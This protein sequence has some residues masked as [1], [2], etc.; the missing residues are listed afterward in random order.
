LP[1]T[2]GT[3]GHLTDREWLVGAMVPVRTANQD[4]EAILQGVLVWVAVSALL[5]MVWALLRAVADSPGRPAPEEHQRRCRSLAAGP[6]RGRPGSAALTPR[7]R[8]CVA[9]VAVAAPW[10]PVPVPPP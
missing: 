8:S 10:V 7:L 9:R 4:G 2:P 6:R 3:G 1:E 5:T